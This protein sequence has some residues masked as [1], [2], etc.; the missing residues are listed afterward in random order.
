MTQR[1]P[2]LYETIKAGVDA[3]L[4]DVHTAIPA[5]VKSYDASTQLAEVEPAIKR[6]FVKPDGTESAR[7][8]P[9]IVNV[10]VVFPRAGDFFLSFPIAPGDFVL[11]VFSER[12]MDQWLE[13]GGK[14]DPIVSTTFDLSDAVAIPGV[15]PKTKKLA[16]AHAQNLVL[17][18]DGG[19][20]IH[21]KPSGQ[22]HLGQETAPKSVA[23]SE[24]I[25][26]HLS[27]LNTWLSTHMHPT[28]GTG[29]PSPPSGAP[30]P[31]VGSFASSVVKVKP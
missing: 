14:Q 19:A 17:G 20:Q 16:Q 12:S 1:T 18:K 28:A 21:I 30:P 25:E 2:N 5:M 13:K 9:V 23:M 22:I 3:A 24:D 27:N 7:D 6:R 8:L 26:T 10:P 31:T 15:Y 29:P 11:L 4:S